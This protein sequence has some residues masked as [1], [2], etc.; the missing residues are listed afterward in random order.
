[1]PS[2]R[3]YERIWS[4][5]GD[6]PIP[7]LVEL[8]LLSDPASLV[9]KA[10]TASLVRTSRVADAN[11]LSLVSC[12]AVNL[13][14]E[15]G[16]CDASSLAYTVLGFV[17]GPRFGDYQ[18][19]FRFGQLGYDLVEKRGLKRFQTRI[20]FNFGSLVIPW[21]RHIRGGRSKP[22]TKAVISILRRTATPT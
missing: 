3:E 18:A 8:P 13:S 12:R 19:G 1:M 6:R 4:I 7:A 11:L 15:S 20:F 2:R 21:T 14:L 16:N 22:Q 9:Y 10:G 5:L 17:A